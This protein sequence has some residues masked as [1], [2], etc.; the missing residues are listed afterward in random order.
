M[1]A[2]LLLTTI[3]YCA[4]LPSDTFTRLTAMWAMDER[5]EDGLVLYSCRIMLPINSPLKGTIKV[6]ESH[7]LV[8]RVMKPPQ[9]VSMF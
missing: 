8:S 1:F 4:K 7:S 3:R 5:Q 2:N 9:T 6:G